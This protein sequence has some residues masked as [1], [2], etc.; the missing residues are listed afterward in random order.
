LESSKAVGISHG[1]KAFGEKANKCIPCGQVPFL[2]IAPARFCDKIYA[3][4]VDESV[5]VIG[6][7]SK[8][9]VIYFSSPVSMATSLV[10]TN[11]AFGDQRENRIQ[12][13][14]K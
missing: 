1:E 6:E 7:K 11:G 9:N 2:A 12:Y 5:C 14:T 4:D 10:F 8:A 3:D 13:K